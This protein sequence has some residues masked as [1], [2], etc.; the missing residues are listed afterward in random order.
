VQEKSIQANATLGEAC[1]TLS[2][3]VDFVHVVANHVNEQQNGVH[4][5]HFLCMEVVGDHLCGV[6]Y[7]YACDGVCE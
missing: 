7:A 3:L 2:L 4:L 5:L 6:A 1:T